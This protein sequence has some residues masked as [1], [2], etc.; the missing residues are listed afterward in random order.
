M[1]IEI[2]YCPRVHVA[3]E[4]LFIHFLLWCFGMWPWLVGWFV[5]WDFTFERFLGGS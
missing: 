2:F 1:E 3:D 4:A 5:C